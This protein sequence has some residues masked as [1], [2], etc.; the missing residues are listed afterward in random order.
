MAETTDMDRDDLYRRV[1]HWLGQ[2]ESA[3][4]LSMAALTRVGELSPDWAQEFQSDVTVLRTKL[5]AL[6]EMVNSQ[7]ERNREDG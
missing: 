2:T 7:G 3:L 6:R 4:D 5:T 1:R